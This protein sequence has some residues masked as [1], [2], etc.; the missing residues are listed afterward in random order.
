[1]VKW[2]GKSS[3]LLSRVRDAWMEMLPVSVNR[4]GQE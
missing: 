4:L 3:L 2:I 1:M